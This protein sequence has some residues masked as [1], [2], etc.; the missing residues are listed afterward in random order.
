LLMRLADSNL[1]ALTQLA[2]YKKEYYA[3]ARRELRR[4]RNADWDYESTPLIRLLGRLNN[5]ESNALLQE[6]LQVKSMDL[7]EEAVLALVKNNRPVAPAVLQKI[8]ADKSLRVH[9]YTELAKCKKE[10]L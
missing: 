7:R 8:A 9:L 6:F 1:V 4:L 10:K 3:F 5:A 2:P